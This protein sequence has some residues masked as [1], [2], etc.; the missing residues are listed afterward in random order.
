MKMHRL[1]AV[2]LVFLLC[3]SLS[4]ESPVHRH[5]IESRD[6]VVDID[7]LIV[8]IARTLSNTPASATSGYVMNRDRVAHQHGRTES[9]VLQSTT[10]QHIVV[11]IESCVTSYSGL[12]FL[13]NARSGFT[14]SP[15]VGDI[16]SSVDATNAAAP[17]VSFGPARSTHGRLRHRSS[18]TERAFSP[19]FGT[20]GNQGV[21]SDPN[22]QGRSMQLCGGQGA[23]SHIRGRM[24]GRDAKPHQQ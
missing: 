3:I 9:E 12:P 5:D 13:E 4:H 14:A 16:P 11:D 7:R 20:C 17:D 15:V 18:R 1:V 24:I 10:P 6:V 2:P 19:A 23:D 22:S 8:L 21:A